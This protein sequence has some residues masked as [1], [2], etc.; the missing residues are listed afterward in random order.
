MNDKLTDI[1]KWL[2]ERHKIIFDLL[3]NH[4]YADD[5]PFE[6]LL[7]ELKESLAAERKL[8]EERREKLAEL[9]FCIAV[10]GDG[11][12]G[13]EMIVR[14]YVCPECGDYKHSPDSDCALARLAKKGEPHAE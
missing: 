12:S 1:E 8:S 11:P 5:T 9:E 10:F 7:Q 14:A 2:S 6:D 4:S 13:E 3:E